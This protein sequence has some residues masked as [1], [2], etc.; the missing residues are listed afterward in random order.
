MHKRKPTMKPYPNER[1]C[2]YQ[3]RL[4]RMANQNPLLRDPEV[5]DGLVAEYRKWKSRHKSERIKRARG[6]KIFGAD[7]AAKY[8]E[9][10][11]LLRSLMQKR[12]YAAKKNQAD[13]ANFAHLYIGVVRDAK[14]YLK[15]EQRQGIMPTFGWGYVLTHKE[16]QR[17]LDAHANL[18]NSDVWRFDM[19]EMETERPR[20]KGWLSKD[21]R[22]DTIKE[23]GTA[24]SQNREDAPDNSVDFDEGE[25]R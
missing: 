11:K 5:R 16:K 1:P 3:K 20:K 12:W 7:Y 21:P 14:R 2:D 4:L 17:V 15:D 22:L 13:V 9:M 24:L 10:D 23:F 19:E 8:A 25:E 6:E 18:A